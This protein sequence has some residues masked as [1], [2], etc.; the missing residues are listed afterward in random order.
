VGEPLIDATEIGDNMAEAAEIGYSMQGL[1]GRTTG[2]GAKKSSAHP[3]RLKKSL[4]LV[5]SDHIES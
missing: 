4:K 5:M 2:R 3:F 1:L